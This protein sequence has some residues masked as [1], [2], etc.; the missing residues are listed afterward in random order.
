MIPGDNI[1]CITIWGILIQGLMLED[2][3]HEGLKWN[4]SKRSFCTFQ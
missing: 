2:T 4:L 1:L 3:V